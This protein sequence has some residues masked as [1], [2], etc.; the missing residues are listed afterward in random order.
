M[1]GII[2]ALDSTCLHEVAFVHY[3]GLQLRALRCAENQVEPQSAYARTRRYAVR[4]RVRIIQQA[5]SVRSNLRR[6]KYARN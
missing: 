6:R 5:A 2:R 3:C 1:T 4:K